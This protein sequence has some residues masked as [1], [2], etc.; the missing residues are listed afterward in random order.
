LQVDAEDGL[1]LDEVQPWDTLEVITQNT[2]YWIRVLFGRLALISG[3]PMYCRQSVLVKLQGSAEGWTD[4]KMGFIGRGLRL[5]FHHPQH[6][7]SII[8][9]PIKEIRGCPTIDSWSIAEIVSI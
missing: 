1:K 8:T 5:K 9:S 6:G 3:H 4:L 2:S 7:K